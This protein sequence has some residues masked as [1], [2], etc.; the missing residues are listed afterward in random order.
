MN[1]LT[2]LRCHRPLTSSCHLSLPS[3]D[4]RPSYSMTQ[5]RLAVFTM[6]TSRLGEEL[7]A[8][9][10]SEE[11]KFAEIQELLGSLSEVQR[12]KVLR[13]REEVSEP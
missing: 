1:L 5:T 6:D 3:S 10:R 9:C 7:L 8:L 13:Y 4:R 11:N 2:L 12:R